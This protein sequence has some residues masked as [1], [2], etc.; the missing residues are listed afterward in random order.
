M[1]SV[2]AVSALTKLNSVKSIFTLK[3]LCYN[4]KVFQ[5]KSNQSSAGMFLEMLQ[6]YDF[7]K[8]YRGLVAGRHARG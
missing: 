1:L 3:N 2:K 6:N 4:K 8:N 7:R 5:L